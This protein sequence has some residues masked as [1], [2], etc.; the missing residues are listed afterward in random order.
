[1]NPALCDVPSAASIAWLD[2]ATAEQAS[3]IRD[4][5]SMGFVV[6][7]YSAASSR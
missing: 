2:G 1:M 3:E 4:E 7:A 5:A 6:G